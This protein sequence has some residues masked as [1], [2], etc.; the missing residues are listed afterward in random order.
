MG[1]T[2]YWRIKKLD[3]KKFDHFAHLCTMIIRGSKIPLSDVFLKDSEVSF[4]GVG[5]D[6]HE[7]FSISVSDTGFN[8][9]K[10]QHKPYDEL[11]VACLYFATNIFKDDISVTSD[12]EDIGEEAKAILDALVRDHK[13]NQIVNE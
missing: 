10:T 9:C 5:D 13:I 4:N 12:G 8:F 7:T 2:R 1:F 11:V 6:A 3:Q